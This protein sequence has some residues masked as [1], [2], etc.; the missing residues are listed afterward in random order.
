MKITTQEEIRTRTKELLSKELFSINDLAQVLSRNRSNV[1]RFI[2]GEQDLNSEAVDK[3]TTYLK[4]FDTFSTYSTYS[5]HSINDGKLINFSI[6]SKTKIDFKVLYKRKAVEVIF[7]KRISEQF[8]WK[9]KEQKVVIP[10]E[11]V[12]ML[13]EVT[14]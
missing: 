12:N 8:Y 14:G 11:A 5:I 9:E 1:S 4:N 10:S 3:L 7:P 6:K 2:T 13:V